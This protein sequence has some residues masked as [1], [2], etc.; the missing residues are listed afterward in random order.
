MKS[1]LQCFDRIFESIQS[2]YAS[3]GES[4][5]QLLDSDELLNIFTYVLCHCSIANLY[6]HVDMMRQFFYKSADICDY[7]ITVMEAV[8]EMIKT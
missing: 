6:T 7:Y 5:N 2:F 4:K 1:L 8:V 3:C